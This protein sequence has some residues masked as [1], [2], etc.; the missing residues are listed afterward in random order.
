MS[1]PEEAM[2]INLQD[3]KNWETAP[4]NLRI[5]KEN[6]ITFTITA[7]DSKDKKSFFKNLS[8]AIKSGLSEKDA[9]NALTTIPAK[10]IGVENILGTLEKGKIAN[11]FIF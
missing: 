10:L 9:L 1:V 8:L 2:N 7:T 3:L 11:F 5:L 6:D 4:F